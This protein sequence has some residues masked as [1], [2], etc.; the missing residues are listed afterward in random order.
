MANGGREIALSQQDGSR[1][2][3][4]FGRKLDSRRNVT[5]TIVTVL[6]KFPSGSKIN[7][8]DKVQ[9]LTSLISNFGSRK[10]RGCDKV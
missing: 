10:G 9:K 7:S 4:S 6:V 2:R 8:F 1:I 3:R 5:E